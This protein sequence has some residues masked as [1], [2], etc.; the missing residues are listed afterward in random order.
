[1][2]KVAKNAHESEDNKSRIISANMLTL[3]TIIGQITFVIM[4]KK[5]F[6]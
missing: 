1:M 3:T 4:K 5:Y 2:K 6:P